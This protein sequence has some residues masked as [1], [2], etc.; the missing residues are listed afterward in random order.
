MR[1]QKFIFLLCESESFITRKE[2]TSF[3]VQLYPVEEM[4]TLASFF[5]LFHHYSF[6]LHAY[7][8]GFLVEKIFA[9]NFK[10]FGLHTEP[11]SISFMQ[12]LVLN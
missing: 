10:G 8:K 11:R 5:D 6:F 4:L 7:V 12:K 3:F 1:A 2:E 9:C